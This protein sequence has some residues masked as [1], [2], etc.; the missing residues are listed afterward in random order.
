[1][2]NILIKKQ[3]GEI[4]RSYTYDAKKNRARSKAATV[5]FF[6]FFAVIMVGVLGGLFTF[7]SL[8]MC[9]A[10]ASAGLDWL[11]FTLMTLLAAF[12]G[13]FGSVFNTYSSLYMAKDNDLLLS[14]PIPVRTIMAARL[15]SVYL[16][17]LMYSAV[18]YLPCLIVYWVVV[19]ITVKTALGGIL[20]LALL[21][22]FVLTLSC[23]LGWIVAK[24]SRKL[25][26]KSF[27]TV[28]V[29]LVFIGAYY[30]FYAQAGD[31]LQE[32]L[33]N[34][35]QYGESIRSGAYPLYLVGRVAVGDGGAM[36][37]V[38]A[39]VLALFA[40][41]WW[42]IARSFLKLA[43][44]TGTVAK[45]EYREKTAR[46]RSA[47]AA[48]LGREL[49]RFTAS[50]NYMLN[51]GMGILGMVIGAGALVWKGGS[52]LPMLEPVFASRPGALSVLLC[53]ALCTLVGMNDMAAPSVSLEGK[54]L[55][56]AQS[57][58]VT[59]WQVLRAKLRMHLLL[60]AVPAALCGICV[61]VVSPAG[62]AQ[63]ALALVVAAL[64]TV[65]SALLNLF[66]GL[67]MPNLHWVSETTPIKQGGA[68]A[69]ALLGGVVYA[70][71]LAAG[72]FLIGWRMGYM[73]FMAAFAVVT[74]AACVLL[75]RWI[76]T[77][78]CAVFAAL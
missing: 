63:T 24:V 11:Y 65:L 18:V 9:D 33:A 59:S 17:G 73:A 76:K 32:L 3:L 61:A 55:W 30:F 5:G 6:V 4:F 48:L 16:M 46:L 70:A 42:L 39:V 12:L 7:V 15:V 21:S 2:L 1:M 51:C 19:D 68:V 52:F 56:L 60:T 58:P 72:F 50:A 69:L 66:L 47:D 31:L 34:A 71:L 13:I 40:L 27:I 23:A 37:M 44:S 64:F 41:V 62:A 49:S 38:T 10:M 29:S 78:G 28:L 20:L 43:T 22:L 35:A 26:N 54:S 77:K 45:K 8:A 53:A 74:L 67:K 36:A 25:R 57:L 75:L 14:L